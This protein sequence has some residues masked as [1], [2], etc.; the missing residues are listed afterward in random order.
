MWRR[1]FGGDRSK[2]LASSK[3]S[4]PAPQSALQQILHEFAHGEIVHQDLDP[5]GICELGVRWKGLLVEASWYSG[6]NARSL[7]INGKSH[8]D[9]GDSLKII[10]A[11]RARAEG[12]LEERIAALDR[13]AGMDPGQ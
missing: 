5:M 1:M 2:P 9:H 7:D 8:P 4:Q 11:A 10:A 12:L 13:I 3:R 6:G